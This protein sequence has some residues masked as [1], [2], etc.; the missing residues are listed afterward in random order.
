MSNFP[1]PPPVGRLVWGSVF[2]KSPVMDDITKQQ[3]VDKQGQP[4]FEYA[5][6]VAYEKGN[7][8]WPALR[9]SFKAADRSFWPQFHGPDGNVLPGVVFADKITDG[10]GVDK[11]GQRYDR[12]EG[13]GGHWVV[14][15]G[16]MFPP[17]VYAK[18]DQGQYVQL[19]DPAAIKV[20]D[21]IQVGGSSA[22]NNS[23]QSPGTH[24]N[25]N[26]VLFA[27]WG[28]PIAKGAD[29]ADVFGGGAVALPAGAS[30]TPVS[31]ATPLP[32]T[33]TPPV[34]P[35][36]S[37]PPAQPYTG[38]RE[39]VTPPPV[40]AAPPAAPVRVMTPLAGANTYE[41]MTGAGWTDATLIQHGYM[42]PS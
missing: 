11:K 29:P 22:T 7:P 23:T 33:V 17:T 12:K 28:A 21:Y 42:L 2:V 27:A 26:Q 4:V 38:Y 32:A 31:G 18:N 3:K 37:V 19:T 9:E 36:A 20:G 13:Y 8:G 25:L 5:I 40:P 10:D 16:S 41:M 39:G 1:N 35:V 24:R 30:T 34:A 15:Y 6:G 14:K